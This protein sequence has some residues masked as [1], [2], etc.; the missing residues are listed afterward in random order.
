MRDRISE[1]VCCSIVTEKIVLDV[2]LH[3]CPG[4]GVVP[5]RTADARLGYLSAIGMLVWT[6]RTNL[7]SILLLFFMPNISR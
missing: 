7:S 6:L 2:M 1:E 3:V 4:V 5:E